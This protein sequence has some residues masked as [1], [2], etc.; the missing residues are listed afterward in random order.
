MVKK[1]LWSM[2]SRDLVILKEIRGN[3]QTVHLHMCYLLQC[4]GAS[5]Q[6]ISADMCPH[7]EIPSKTPLFLRRQYVKGK[8]RSYI[9]VRGYH[10]LG[11]G[12]GRIQRHSPNTFMP[13]A[14]ALKLIWLLVLDKNCRL[15]GLIP[16]LSV[17]SL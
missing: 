11:R 12:V 9:A 16:D 1:G 15:G 6:T 14:P 8:E 10:R 3:T 17:S 5:W 4:F 7:S 13:S 2:T